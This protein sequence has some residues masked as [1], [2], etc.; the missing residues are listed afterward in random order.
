MKFSTSELA[1]LSKLLE[2]ALDLSEGARES[3]IKSLPD[4]APNIESALR[5]MLARD[6]N[7]DSDSLL[8]TLP[9]FTRVPAT[10]ASNA[11]EAPREG[12]LFG[13]Y[14]LLRE[15]GRGG[16]GSVWLADRV[17]GSLTRQVALKL[18][19]ALQDPQ[20]LERFR[21]ERDI[22]ASFT[23]PNIAQIYDAGV[24]QEGHPFIALEYVEGSSL[25]AYCDRL[26]LN[27]QERLRLFVQVLSA[28]QYA[29]SHLVIH[30]DLKPSNI[31]A[32]KDGEVKLL[33]FGIAKLITGDETQETELTQAGARALTF[34]YAA[35]EQ[36]LGKPVSTASDVYSLGVVLCELLAGARPYSI[37]RNLAMASEEALLSIPIAKP[38]QVANGEKAAEAR[39]TTPKKLAAMLKG[40]LD[41]IVLK[42]L[43]SAPVDRYASADAFA[44]DIQRYLQGE[45][46]LAQPENFAYRAKKF[47][48]RHKLPVLASSLA[49]LAIVAG[50]GASLYQAHRAQQR[51]A[52]VRTLANRFVFDF[53]A[54]I[55]DTPGTLAARRMVAS[56]GR[57]YLASLAADAGNDDGLTRELAQAYYRLSRVESSAGENGPSMEHLRRSIEI[58]K[59]HRDDC[60]GQPLERSRYITAVTDLAY[61]LESSQTPE[62]SLKFANEAVTLARDWNAST[63]NEP[64]AQ[65]AL[66]TALSTAGDAYA[67]QGKSA[68]GRKSLEE[69]SHLGETL[70]A[71]NP[72]DQDLTYD[73]ARTKHWLAFAVFNTEGPAAAAAPEAEA[74]ALVDSLLTQNPENTR[75][76]ALRIVIASETT[77]HLNQ[78][79][80]KD[81]TVRAQAV[82]SAAEAYALARANARQNP[83][84]GYA[85]DLAAVMAGQLGI[86]LHESK[87]LDE[88]LPLYMEAAGTIDQLLKIDPSDR[89]YLYMKAGN[90]LNQGAYL[91]SRNRFDEVGPRVQGAEQVLQEIRRRWPGDLNAKDLMVTVLLNRTDA[92]RHL[93]Q[94]DEAKETCRQGLALAAELIADRKDSKAPVSFLRNLRDYAKLLNVPDPTLALLPE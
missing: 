74:K 94:M 35:P 52:Q 67:V 40:D 13:P 12:R 48:L 5:E 32:G 90:L 49:G 60:C 82:E 76:R 16:M 23:H 86:Q 28:V 59:A 56:T 83:G 33:D 46:V 11:E 85:L 75:W 78:L 44:Q 80:A 70:I 21:R 65:R 73:V 79:A 25:L 18:P 31:L 89:R 91:S 71:Q 29:H 34:D 45:A 81:P 39:A 77:R 1:E 72:G 8:D 20:F 36:I 27:L 61:A 55:R 54:A 84:D 3:W 9:K 37:K 42:A 19:H 7:V 93:G 69:A 2:V 26:R 4:L 15:L 57:E 47:V 87:R 41:T 64:L 22:L 38:S 43:K 58:Q 68:E 50:A 10:G 51:F 6:R 63:P 88:V 92:Q 24:T 53:E 17:D 30:R 62:D 66:L 14:R